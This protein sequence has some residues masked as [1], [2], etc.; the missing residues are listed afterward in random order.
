VRRRL[1]AEMVRRGLATSLGE[2]RE[3]ILAGRV[4]VGGRPAHKTGTLVADD[5]AV[6]V[7][8]PSPPFAS[9]GGEKLADALDRFGIDPS[10]RQCLDVGA[11]TGG[12]TDVLLE[13][14]ATHV[15]AVDV[16]YGQLA[17]HLRTDRRVTVMERTNVRDL[18]TRALPYRPNLIV[19]DLSFISLEK[20]VP[21]LAR[22][23]EAGADLVLLVKPQFE[24]DRSDV[25]AGG[26]VVDPAVRRRAVETVAAACRAAG[27][28]PMHVAAS[29]LLGPA[30][31]VEIFLWAR[32][33]EAG[34]ELDIDAAL[35]RGI[36]EGT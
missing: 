6:D 12:F 11:S 8:R 22:I 21:L 35:E 32:N 23:G 7:S 3:V 26:V 33:G 20:V 4:I 18:Q 34:R 16:G 28:G 10:G 25:A 17:W 30:G 13:R 24:A 19:A 5:E 31:N 27:V 29:P 14:G 36:R 1:D 9:R 15:V 2:A